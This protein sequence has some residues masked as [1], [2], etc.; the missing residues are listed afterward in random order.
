MWSLDHIRGFCG[1][2]TVYVDRLSAIRAANVADN[3]ENNDFF[4][5]RNPGIEPRQSRDFG[6]GKVGR[7]PGI[8]DP[9]IAIPTYESMT[10]EEKH[11]VN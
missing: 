7:D 9:G 5:S 3:N 1:S 8:R 6:I 4:Q 2:S 11:I 10:V